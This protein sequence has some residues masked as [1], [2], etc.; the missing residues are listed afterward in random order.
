M[1]LTSV[2]WSQNWVPLTKTDPAEPE[3]AVTRS[4]NRQVNFT[5]EL[6]GFFSTLIT[7]AGVDY[8][9]LA[10]PKCGVTEAIGEPE[11]PVI[12]KR[13]ALPPHGNQ[14]KI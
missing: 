3:I 10:I 5:I 7:E 2:A 13:I 12:R 1:L 6:S 14:T 8:Q 9:R 4:D 11:I